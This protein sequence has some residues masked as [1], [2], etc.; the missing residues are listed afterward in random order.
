MASSWS[1]LVPVIS[2]ELGVAAYKAGLKGRDLEQIKTWDKLY[3][4]H[5]ELLD[6]KDDKQANEMFNALDPSI[7]DMLK[8]TFNANYAVRPKDWTIGRVIGNALSLANPI[9]VGFS[10]LNTWSQG[11]SALPTAAYAA[12]TGQFKP[13]I[14]AVWRKDWDGKKIYD[15]GATAALDTAYGA[16]MGTLAR[17]IAS[18]MTP[19]E[20]ITQE[21]G[22]NPELESALNFMYDQPDKFKEILGD[23]KR[24][25][26]SVGR[27]AAKGLFGGNVAT[28]FKNTWQEE[29]FDKISG[30]YDATFQIAADPLTYMT[31][32]F[33]PALKAGSKLAKIYETTVRETGSVE[34]GVKAVFEG[35]NKLGQPTKLSKDLNNYWDSLGRLLKKYKDATTPAAK[36]AARNEIKL[37]FPAYNDDNI[38]NELINYKDVAN[39]VDGVVD[40][41]SA[42]KFFADYERGNVDNL[43][44]GR[45]NSM[46]FYRNNQIATANRTSIFAR[47]TRSYLDNLFN[48]P[49]DEKVIDPSLEEIVK[50][51]KEVAKNVAS[52]AKELDNLRKSNPAF[53]ASEEGLKGGLARMSRLSS[54]APLYKPIEISDAKVLETIDTVNQLLRTIHPKRIADGLTEVFKTLNQG[55]RVALLR[56]TFTDIL[57]SSGLGTTPKGLDLINEVIGEKFITGSKRL[58]E[59]P[60]GQKVVGTIKDRIV[61]IN[62]K[63]YIEVTG[64]T[65]PNEFSEIVGNVDWQQ[66]GEHISKITLSSSAKEFG[67]ALSF[68]KATSSVINGKLSNDLTNLWTVLTLVPKLGVRGTVDELFFFVNYAPKEALYNFFSLKGLAGVKLNAISK[69]SE[70]GLSFYARNV[71]KIQDTIP[72][73][74]LKNVFQNALRQSQGDRAVATKIAQQDL[75]DMAFNRFTGISGNNLSPED[76]LHIRGL[77]INV[78]HF[79]DAISSVVAGHMLGGISRTKLSGAQVMVSNLTQGLQE[80]GFEQAKKWAKIADD[81]SVEMRQLV[82]YDEFF[83]MAAQNSFKKFGF[84]VEDP[85]NYVMRNNGLK[86]PQDFT[87][88]LN[89]MMAAATDEKNVEG[90]RRFIDA[91][92]DVVNNQGLPDYFILRNRFEA[93]L[94]SMREILHGT[95]DYGVFNDQLFN[96]IKSSTKGKNFASGAASIDRARF[97]NATKNNIIDTKD[98]LT[99]LVPVGTELNSMMARLGNDVFEFMDKQIMSMYRAPAFISLFLANMDRYKKN[100]FYQSYIDNTVSKLLAGGK[101]SKSGAVKIATRQ[102]DRYFTEVSARAASDLMLKYV[103]NPQIRSQL[104]FSVRNGARF[105]R[106]TEDFIRRMY[107]MKD[108][109]LRTAMRMRLSALG[110]EASGIVHEDSQGQKYVVMPMDDAMFQVLDKPIRALTGGTSGYM[111]PLFGDFTIKLSQVN[112]SFGPDAA[113]PT[114]SGPIA[115]AN[116]WLF[117]T[118]AGRFGAT[119]REVAD[120]VDNALLGNIG[121]NLTLRKAIVPASLDRVLKIINADEKDKQEVTAIHQAIAYDAAHGRGLSPNATPE[122]RYEYIK[123]IRIAAHNVIIMRNLLG[124]MPVPFTPSLRESK[125]VP[126]FLKEVGIASITQEFYDIYENVLKAPNPRLDNPYEEALAIY[127]GKNPGKLVYT[128]SRADKTQEIA[129]NKTDEVKKWY[130]R[131]KDLVNKYGEV[132]WL[133]APGTG[134]FS[135][136]AYAWFE[137]SGMLKNKDLETYLKDV[138]VAEDKALYFDVEDYAREQILAATTPETVKQV[139]ENMQKYRD[140]LLI[141]NPLLKQVIESGQYGTAKEEAM[142][143]NLTNMLQDP[144]VEMDSGTRI[145]LRQATEIVNVTLSKFLSGGFDANTEYKREVRDLAIRDLEILGRVDSQ[146]RQANKAIFL[147]ILKNY[148]KDVRLGSL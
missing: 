75:V 72:D 23:Y 106:A 138:Q 7:Q 144:S 90:L 1:D 141:Q 137:A 52:P 86:T 62:N 30:V 77:F 121:D 28:P 95:T 82:H 135:A 108:V 21:G 18:G 125:D 56:G 71:Q 140:T 38:I 112:P 4:K 115:S 64:P 55:E 100:K 20:I 29:A 24:T 129:F 67:G 91:S 51:Y 101:I 65:H 89:E 46:T 119:G 128:V 73:A 99:N 93:I 80:A 130:I 76:K 48:K 120:V 58:I 37:N 102:A 85:I 43:L 146:I 123:N 116:V 31:L 97:F 34:L 124:L 15:R 103:D 53:K 32:G 63:N 70:E 69:K 3:S 57:H 98:K 45:T 27:F 92:M 122:E 127:I 78:P 17:G 79:S 44:N 50:G 107:R 147:P 25:Q 111:Q 10:A 41:N 148:S 94:Y 81:A 145:K 132:A 49:I 87:N 109:S 22:V 126:D 133:A 60:A 131:N 40:A 19:G 84:N 26:F 13:E 2:P 54:R 96:A 83:R 59:I 61:N 16:G 88:A 142:L 134:D 47:K 104:A 74:E 14:F 118:I 136:G 5:R 12:A 9:K 35:K 68:L 42:K 114:L 6:I 139:K 66:L 8:Q 39:T 11:I 33:G 143:N 36:M 105:Y 113:M 110:L 117:K